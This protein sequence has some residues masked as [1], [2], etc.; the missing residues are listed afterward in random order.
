MKA[1]SR[2][3]F[4]AFSYAQAITGAVLF[5]FSRYPQFLTTGLL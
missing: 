4:Y 2:L 3:E 5:Q 1:E